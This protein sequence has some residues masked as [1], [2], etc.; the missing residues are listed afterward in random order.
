VKWGLAES[1][2]RGIHDREAAHLILLSA[3]AALMDVME[4]EDAWLTARRL[5]L[6]QR[7]GASAGCG[8]WAANGPPNV[9]VFDVFAS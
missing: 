6:H 4:W 2:V 5:V 7:E 3:E 9:L 1:V 8:C